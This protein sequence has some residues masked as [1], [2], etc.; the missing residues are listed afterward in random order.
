MA[1]EG[2]EP[3]TEALATASIGSEKGIFHLT[4][5]NLG[6]ELKWG[7]VGGI[8]AI[9][10]IGDYYSEDKGEIANQI[11]RGLDPGL[12]IRSR[13]ERVRGILRRFLGQYI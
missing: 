4:K 1:K 3:T 12:Q 13:G 10:S 8:L 11:Y 7:A 5:E 6:N 9:M 2:N